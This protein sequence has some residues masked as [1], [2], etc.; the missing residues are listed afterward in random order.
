MKKIKVGI[1][2]CGTIGTHVALMASKRFH[3]KMEVR[4]LTDKHSE[5]SRHLAKR[6]KNP[7]QV[8][9]FSELMQRSDV[10]IEAASAAVSEKAATR[11]LQHHKTILIMSVGGLLHLKNLEK[12]TAQ[13]RGKLWVPSGAV[14]GID[15]LRAAKLGKLK[16]VRLITR[17]PPQGLSGAP[18]FQKRKFPS[19][20]KNQEVRIFSGSARQ[21]VRAFP[22]NVNVAAILSLAGL[23]A[24]KTQVELWT[25]LKYK[26]NQHEIFVSGAFGTVRTETSNVPSPENPKTSYLAVLSAIATLQDIFSSIKI[27]T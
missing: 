25:S 13:S 26:R 17:K 1:L 20:K 21:A 14:A 5:K 12:K 8:V 18:Y 24:E 6:L 15:A 9:S 2:G 11:A 4:Y 3:D 23:G 7:V 10:I 22:Q 27:G 16:K 19:L